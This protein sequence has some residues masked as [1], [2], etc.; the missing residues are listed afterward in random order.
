MFVFLAVLDQIGIYVALLKV[1]PSVTKVESARKFSFVLVFA[2][3]LFSARRE[4]QRR[5]SSAFIRWGQKA[6]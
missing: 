6:E 2:F 3:E 1:V 5:L 4:G